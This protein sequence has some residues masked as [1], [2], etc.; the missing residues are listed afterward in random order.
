MEKFL[1]IQN[2]SL[3]EFGV[4]NFKDL[5]TKA[6][7][8]G[9]KGLSVPMSVEMKKAEEES[10]I[11][12]AVFSTSDEDR[13]G[14]I[15]KQE[16]DLKFF[17]KNPVFLDSHNYD[18]IEYII[19]KVLNI[20][21]DGKLEGDIKFFTDNPKG[22]LAKQAAEQGFLNTTSVGF[23]P[24]EFD[25]KG[26]ILK[27]ELLE[28]SGVSVPANPRAL[29]EKKDAEEVIETPEETEV[30]EEKVEEPKIEEKKVKNNNKSVLNKVVREMADSQKKDLRVLNKCIKKIVLDNKQSE[31]KNVYRIVRR[32]VE[33][34]I[35]SE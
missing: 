29:L 21:S 14:D 4:N 8:E 28:I 5:W 27:S 16:W 10:D 7:A 33:K 25:D 17:R 6:Q 22:L 19:G 9:Y 12:H 23:L 26:I 32:L 11:F 20:K 35:D 13:H 30:V 24:K 34:G 31:K 15:V 1:Q 18:S 3:E 2:K